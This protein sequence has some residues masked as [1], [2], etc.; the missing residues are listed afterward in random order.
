MSNGRVTW[1]SPGDPPDA[2]PDIASAMQEP[3]GLLAAGGDLSVERLV[4]AYGAGIFPWFDDGQPI[5]WWSPDPRCVLMPAEYHVS[6]RLRREIA[7]STLEITFNSA[8]GEVIRACAGPRRSQQGTWITPDMM[9]AYEALHDDGWAHSVELRSAGRLVGGIYGLAIGRVFFGE[10]MFSE[11]TNASKIAML[12][13]CQVLDDN[14]CD[15]IDCQVVSGHL[16][17]LGAKTIPRR[18]FRRL[19]QDRCDP[20][21][22]FTGWPRTALAVR[23]LRLTRA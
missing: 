18:D 13:L 17:T 15:L 19:L 11:R 6:R 2:F 4:H 23:D 5:L 22:R 12:G 14:G 3:D 20:A 1:L 8:F 16:M 21:T 7:E 9:R 10:S